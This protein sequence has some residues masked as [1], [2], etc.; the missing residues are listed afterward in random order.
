MKNKKLNILIVEDEIIAQ[1]YLL[2]I[3]ESINFKNCFTAISMEEAL[4]IVKNNK[5]DLVFMDINI[6][7]STDGIE[8]AK[9]LNELYFLPIIYTTAYGDSQSILEGSETNLFGYIIK[10]FEKNDVEATLLIALK[11]IK[12]FL[13]NSKVLSKSTDILELG[14]NQKYNLTAQTFYTNNIPINLTKK[15]TDI[16]YILCKN[17][18]QNISYDI[19]KEKVWNNKDISNS[20][21]RDTVSRLK[22]KTPNLNIETII[23]FGYILKTTT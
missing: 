15:E 11:R 3:L 8:C 6:H 7:G 1:E 23:N 5:I 13:Q 18:N 21:I 19:L 16:L 14:E 9:I 10:P 22:R 12:P 17:R 2:N 20:T 4:E